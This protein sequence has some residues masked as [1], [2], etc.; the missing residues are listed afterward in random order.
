MKMLL[1]RDLLDRLALDEVLT[2]Y[3]INRLHNQR[4]PP[5]ASRQS[6]QPTKLEI[7]GVTPDHTQIASASAA[8]FFCRLTNGFT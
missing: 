4:P 7:G 6:R 3:P 5:P 1:A 8:S 2:P